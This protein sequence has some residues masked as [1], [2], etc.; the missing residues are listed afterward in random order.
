MPEQDRIEI[1]Q[2]GRTLRGSGALRVSLAIRNAGVPAVPY[3]DGIVAFDG[4]VT[5]HELQAMTDAEVR[6]TLASGRRHTFRQ[7]VVMNQ[8][9]DRRRPYTY[10]LRMDCY[11][12]VA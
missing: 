9:A 11:E 6:V 1:E 7:A 8:E 4:R 12:V 2:S 3:V 5:F 10:A